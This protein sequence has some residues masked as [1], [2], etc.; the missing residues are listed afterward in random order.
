M[1]SITEHL[2]VAEKVLKEKCN[3][4]KKLLSCLIGYTYHNKE[5]GKSN[6]IKLMEERFKKDT[7][8]N[9]IY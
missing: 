8:N 7:V 9:V 6:R 4:K 3:I 5:L 1:L 2:M